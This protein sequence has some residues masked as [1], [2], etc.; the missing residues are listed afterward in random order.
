MYH[1]KV[2]YVRELV[3]VGYVKLVKCAGHS[4][5]QHVSDALT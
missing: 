1:V 2:H 4:S 5:T 3:R